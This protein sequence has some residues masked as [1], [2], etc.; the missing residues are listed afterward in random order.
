M[1]CCRS[2]VASKHAG[3]TISPSARLLDVSAPRKPTNRT[4]ASHFLGGA[5]S[6]FLLPPAGSNPGHGSPSETLQANM[7]RF[8]NES[9]RKYIEDISTMS[10]GGV[11]MNTATTRGASRSNAPMAAASRA[12][13]AASPLD[14]SMPSRHRTSGI[15]AG[16]HGAARR[17]GFEDAETHS[18]TD[19]VVFERDEAGN[20][21]FVRNSSAGSLGNALGGGVFGEVNSKRYRT[22]MSDL[23][24]QVRACNINVYKLLEYNHNQ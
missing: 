8:Y 19:S 14:L 16:R 17:T 11:Q 21:V 5:S 6:Q 24:V 23:Q 12:S 1:P 4:D 13:D 10:M 22:Q 7:Q 2:H 3:N 18:D 15:D 9:F 20:N